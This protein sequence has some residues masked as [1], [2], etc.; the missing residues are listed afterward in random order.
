MVVRGEAVQ[1][2][3]R[4]ERGGEEERVEE[5]IFRKRPDND[6]CTREWRRSWSRGPERILSIETCKIEMGEWVSSE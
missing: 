2:S 5:D 6:P 1:S 4:G 3:F